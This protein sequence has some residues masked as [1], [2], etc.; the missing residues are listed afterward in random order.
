M[1]YK[2]TKL[3]MNNTSIDS[4]DGYSIYKYLDDNGEFDYEK[5]KQVQVDGNKRKLD[6]VWVIEEN[7]QFLSDY[8]AKLNV[9]FQFGLCHGT[10]QGKEQAWFKK[11]FEL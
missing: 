5:Y 6:N 8:L 1:G 4:K 11:I 7:I 2:I 3:D 10:R 9:S